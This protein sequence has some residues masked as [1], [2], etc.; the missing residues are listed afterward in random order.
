[1]QFFIHLLTSKFYQVLRFVNAINICYFFTYPFWPWHDWIVSDT[2]PH[3][4]F[5][6]VVET[7]NVVKSNF[8]GK[9]SVLLTIKWN[10]TYLL[11]L[12]EHFCQTNLR[13]LLGFGDSAFFVKIQTIVIRH[14]ILCPHHYSALVIRMDQRPWSTH[15]HT[16]I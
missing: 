2:H 1:M 13:R 12:W 8:V 3:V 7:G 4:G 10:A 11:L 9:K 6:W 14:R 15:Q 5:F 16:G